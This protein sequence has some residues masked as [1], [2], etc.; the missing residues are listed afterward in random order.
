MLFQHFFTFKTTQNLSF[1]IEKYYFHQKLHI[2][3]QKSLFQYFE[4]ILTFQIP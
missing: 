1:F 3:H 4:D 2:N